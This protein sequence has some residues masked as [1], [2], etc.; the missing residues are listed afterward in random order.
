[1]VDLTSKAM[2]VKLNISQWAARKHDKKASA[3]VAATHGNDVNMGRYHKS[4]IAKTAL[5]DI[6]KLAGTARTHHYENTLPWADDGARILPATNYFQYQTEQRAIAEQFRAAVAKFVNDYPSF[7]ADARISLNGLFNE[8]DYPT[9]VA[10]KFS[11]GTVILPLPAA[12]DFRVSIG[13]SEEASIR[14]EIETTLNSAI[15]G[16]TRDLWQR[17]YDGVEHMR[18]RLAAYAIDPATGKTISTFRD[19]LVGNLQD[20]VGLLPR[21]NLTG[22]PELAAMAERLSKSLCQH[23]AQTLRENELVRVEVTRSAEQILSDMAG[24]IG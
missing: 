1:M 20:L 17:V 16:A 3:E 8:A 12:G 13:V 23:D 21:L 22:D 10:D 24:Y 11:I 5:A 2:L 6:A 14:A 4:L 9:F 7:V 19:S 15:A 18:E